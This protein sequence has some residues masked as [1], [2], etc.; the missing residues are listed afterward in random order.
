MSGLLTP[1]QEPIEISM[2]EFCLLADDIVR[3]DLKMA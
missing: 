1:F 2:Q 3:Q